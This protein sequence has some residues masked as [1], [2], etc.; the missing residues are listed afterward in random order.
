MCFNTKT[1]ITYDPY[2][3]GTVN[4]FFYDLRNRMNKLVKGETQREAI[5]IRFDELEKRSF[6]GNLL[7]HDNP[8]ADSLHIDEVR[9]FAESVHA[10]KLVISCENCEEF[11]TY[12]QQMK[13]LVC[14]NKKCAN[15]QT[16]LCK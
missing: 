16:I 13:R 11:M 3:G 4:D 14:S 8:L 9:R 5:T 7:A 12:L 15:P 2:S 1:K 10:L 6:M